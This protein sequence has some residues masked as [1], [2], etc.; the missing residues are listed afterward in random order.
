MQVFVT[1]APASSARPSSGNSSARAIRSSAS[2]APTRARRRWPPPAPRP[3]TATL[4]TWTACADGAAASDGRHPLRLRPRLLQLRGQLRKD[5]RAIEALGAALAG[6]DRPLIVTSGVG[7]GIAGA[8]PSGDR[9]CFQPRP[10]S[11]LPAS[12]R[13]LT[14]AGAA[15]GRWRQRV[16]GASP[17]G[18]RHRQARPHHPLDRRG[19]PRASP[20]MWATALNR[21]S[22]AHVLDTARLY[23]LAL[24]R[25][26]AGARYHAVAEEGVPVRDIA[27]VIGR[28]L[29]RAGRLP[30]ARRRP[31]PISAGLAM[32]VG[33]GPL[34]LQRADA[35]AS[36]LE[37]DRA[38][39][40]CRPRANALLRSL[41]AR[42]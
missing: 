14:A 26:E 24:E 21:W 33:L 28:G 31:P 13:K 9:R 36:R 5:K 23:R 39:P 35:G 16:G 38:G 41:K 3:T 11:Q 34:C 25:Q 18:P 15:G 29:R 19:P 27:E 30:V 37:P 1:G 10:N 22:A 42:G 32:F 20:P 6:S 8:G 4:K 12:S 17:P 7:M 2:P 40:D